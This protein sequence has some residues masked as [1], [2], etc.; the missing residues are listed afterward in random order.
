MGKRSSG[1]VR[2]ALKALMKSPDKIS[3]V[4]EGAIIRIDSQNPD[5]CKT[6]HR[7]LSWIVHAKRLLTCQELQHALAVRI[8]SRELQEEYIFRD[9]EEIV[10]LC[11]GLVVIN[12]ESNTVQ[13]MHDTT[14][15]YFE[16]RTHQPDWIRTA[17]V[18]I[19]QNCLTYLSFDAFKTGL[20]PTDEE[21]KAQL[22]PYPLYDYAARNWG[23]HARAASTE[24]KEPIMGFLES[25]A[26]VPASSQP[27]IASGNCDDYRQEV[28]RQAADTLQQLI[29]DFLEQG[30]KLQASFRVV[31]SALPLDF[32]FPLQ[33]TSQHTQNSTFG[34]QALHVTAYFGLATLTETLLKS[35]KDIECKDVRGWTPLR[36]AAIGDSYKTVQFLIDMHVNVDSKDL[37]GQST[38]CWTLGSRLTESRYSGPVTISNN[39][40]LLL[41]SPVF[42]KSGASFETAL[43]KET[44]PRTSN[45]IIKLLVHKT[46][47]IDATR[48][49]D[50]RT[51]LSI[52]AE[53]WQWSIVE[54][55]MEQGASI[56]SKD[57]GGMTVL[58][59]A[60]QSPRKTTVF[61]S[62]HV[63]DE[64]NVH[65]GNI[66]GTID[67][68][69]L[70]IYDNDI[71]EKVVE[72]AISRLI[73]TDLEAQ[74]TA[75]RTALSL[76]AENRFYT[77]VSALLKKDANV[78]SMD[79]Q[80]M[81]PL[82]WASGL[83]RFE[84]IVIENFIC[85]DR[86]KSRFGGNKLPEMR[87]AR[88]ATSS[89][90]PIERIVRL[91]LDYGADIEAKDTFGQTALSIA[92][93]D[94]L[95]IIARLLEEYGLPDDSISPGNQGFTYS[96]F[97]PRPPFQGDAHDFQD[98]QEREYSKLLLAIL[99]CR[100]SFRIQNIETHDDSQ[101]LIHACA[102]IG[103]LRIADRSQVL[104]MDR[105][106]FTNVG[107]CDD[108][109]LLI[110]AA[111]IITNLRITERSLVLLQEKSVTV[112]LKT[113]DE[114]RLLIQ[115]AANIINLTTTERSLVLIQDKSVTVNIYTRDESRLLIQAA[116]NINN[117]RIADC[118][119]VFIKEEPN[120]QNITTYDKSRLFLDVT[121]G[122]IGSIST[123]EES[124]AYISGILTI[125]QVLVA[126]NS[127]ILTATGGD[128]TITFPHR[129]DFEAV[130]TAVREVLD[131][132]NFNEKFHEAL[133]GSWDWVIE[134]VQSLV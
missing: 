51:A 102:N 47:D 88:K 112:N 34:I 100:C 10:A 129:E 19:A 60:L 118:S 81:T 117:I 69:V 93:N 97:H 77:I 120:V 92:T 48:D 41:G 96:H 63:L 89:S 107:A 73:G 50:G 75:G 11:A 105:P 58:L 54:L 128:Q 134:L 53:N 125:G 29:L 17:Q 71:S 130:E 5:D 114:S 61:D 64:A 6:A 109:Q 91:L 49:S 113:R 30:S 68:S 67:P 42:W 62:V 12:E 31:I 124:K 84:H 115:A 74:D 7:V 33:N 87:P 131:N 35:G 94:G 40:R 70:D 59:W 110:Q 28:P 16:D 106:N 132:E 79:H 80:Q 57:R 26:R 36:W 76:A 15:M 126:D 2:E 37:I 39:A 4:Y 22:Q 38:L 111:S 83:P 14:R 65:I 123:R 103:N 8:G 52:A 119:L 127:L 18:A 104:I 24:V 43:P 108:S 20:C 1:D 99:E 122:I 32:F 72:P 95:D 86:S 21:F 133:E 9:L 121:A 116:A 55:L 85:S 23:H 78:N 44:Q 98:R 13:L 56:N 90:K 66:T 101:L 46:S 82:L 45:E 25:G 3:T 27:M